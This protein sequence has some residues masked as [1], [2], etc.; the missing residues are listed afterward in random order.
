MIKT[1]KSIFAVALMLVL[2][3]LLSVAGSNLAYASED[4]DKNNDTVIFGIAD[5]IPGLFNPLVATKTTDQD[6]NQVVFPSLLEMDNEGNLQ[7]YLAESYEVNDLT[8]TFHLRKNAKWHDGVDLTAADVAFTFDCIMQPNFTGTSY[9]RLASI[10]GAADRH[11]GK[12]DTVTGIKVVDDYTIEFT[13]E[14]AYAP[15]FAAIVS[16]GIVPEHIWKDIP[17]E[18]FENQVDLL[19]APIGCGP[20]KMTE[21]A[22]GQYVKLEAFDDFFLGAPKIKHLV[23]KIVSTDSIPAEFKNGTLDIVTVKDLEN[24]E[25]ELL[26]QDVGLDVVR[27]PNNVYRY[28][29]INLRQ[30][31]FQ[32]KALREALLYAIDR[33][34]IVE[35]LLEGNGSVIEAPFLPAGWAKPD[36]SQLVKRSYDPEKAKSILAEAGYTDKDGNGV[37]ESPDGTE[38]SFVYKIPSDN[39]IT[40]H[41]AL[42]VQQNWKEIGVDVSLQQMEYGK[43]AQ[44]AIFDHDFDFYTLNCQFGFDPDIMLWWHSSAATD[45]KGKPSWNFDGYKNPELDKVIDASNT[46]LKQEERQKLLNECAKIISTD[47]PMIFLYVQDNA[48]AYPRNLQGFAP[49]TFNVFYNVYNW[50]YVD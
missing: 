5:S 49:Y 33:E 23:I 50:Q 24:A 18:E 30:E 1:E 12:A 10:V 40:E 25:L 22:E 32:D 27:F 4:N 16:R 46:S 36:D 9:K 44:E 26:T 6:I 2:S 8:Y 3:L 43:L 34:G 37:L 35:S 45:E 19:H 17:V 39:P 48:Y 14:K 20:F 29:G 21:Y 38:L 28:I 11:D 47:V 42:V 41:V 7:P 31:I 13:L 15:T